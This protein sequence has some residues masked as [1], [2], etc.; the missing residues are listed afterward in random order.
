MKAYIALF[1]NLFVFMG[2]VCVCHQKVL[3]GGESSK[4]NASPSPIARDAQSIDNAKPAEP[5][6]IELSLRLKTK[7]GERFLEILVKNSSPKAIEIT[8]EGFVPAWSVW[9]W[10]EWR[11][12]GRKAEY[13]AN[14]AGNPK[15]KASRNISPGESIRWGEIP[16][17]H[18]ILEYRAT[19]DS[20]VED[21]RPRTITVLP[22]SR[23][24]DLKI[25]PGDINVEKIG[26]G[27]ADGATERFRPKEK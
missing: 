23:W 7:G 20:P 14:V 1:V 16:L 25:K 19:F 6:Q 22:S 15:A 2:A 9:A 10:F 13:V 21:N 5:Y 12:D 8:S 18:L 4:T 11:V 26:R 27:S 3:F 24:K 17:R